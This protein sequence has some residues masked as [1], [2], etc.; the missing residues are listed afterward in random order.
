MSDEL[1]QLHTFSL[2]HENRELGVCQTSVLTSVS[3][4]VSGTKMERE[5]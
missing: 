3:R 2:T 5:N 4:E 1:L